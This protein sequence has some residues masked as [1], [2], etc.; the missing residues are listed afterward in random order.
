MTIV[1]KL[2]ASVVR[3]AKAE[4]ATNAGNATM[5]AADAVGIGMIGRAHA[6]RRHGKGGM[7]TPSKNGSC[8]TAHAQRAARTITSLAANTKIPFPGHGER[9]R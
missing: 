7:A 8:I 5:T 1:G 2:F 6:Q 9:S 4:F 3:G